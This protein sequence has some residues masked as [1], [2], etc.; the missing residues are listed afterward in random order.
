MSR[1]SILRTCAALVC[2]LGFAAFV[3][4][5]VSEDNETIKELRRPEDVSLR[6]KN[7]SGPLGLVTGPAGEKEFAIAA[8]LVAGYGKG[9][10]EQEVEVLLQRQ[11]ESW[12]VSVAPFSQDEARE[13]LIE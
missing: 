2:L 11:E 7:F 6:A 8:A 13:F 1:S 4:A 12:E 9:K 3:P 10:E 5:A